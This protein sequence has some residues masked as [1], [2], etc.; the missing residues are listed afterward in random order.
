MFIHT[1]MA[2]YIYIYIN[3][4]IKYIFSHAYYN[5][6]SYNLKYKKKKN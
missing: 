4:Y 2:K 6:F 5:R 3:N 1:I